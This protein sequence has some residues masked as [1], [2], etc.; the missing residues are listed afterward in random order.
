M[1]H[2][3]CKDVAECGRIVLISD[4]MM[5]TTTCTGKHEDLSWVTGGAVTMENIVYKAYVLNLKWKMFWW[6][7]SQPYI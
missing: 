5:V 6:C 1:Y 3:Y 4:N 2:V 7:Y